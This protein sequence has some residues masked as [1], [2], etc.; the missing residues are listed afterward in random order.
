M[1]WCAAKTIWSTDGGCASACCARPLRPQHSPTVHPSQGDT[2]E[3]RICNREAAAGWHTCALLSF[4]RTSLSAASTRYTF[5]YLGRPSRICV[6]RNMTAPLPQ[7]LQTVQAKRKARDELISAFTHQNAGIIEVTFHVLEDK[8]LMLTNHS[9]SSPLR[10]TTPRTL[11]I[12][13][14]PSMI[15]RA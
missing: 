10:L 4:W 11:R 14:R 9:H 13:T 7:W 15:L 6:H 12:H 3:R 8:Y 5:S 1:L 2:S